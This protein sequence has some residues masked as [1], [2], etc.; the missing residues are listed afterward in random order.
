MWPKEFLPCLI[1]P[2]RS[3]RPTVN[4]L[5]LIRP[6]S[7]LSHRFH[8]ESIDYRQGS[9]GTRSTSSDDGL[10]WPLPCPG[11]KLVGSGLWLTG[12]LKLLKVC[13][14]LLTPGR[15]ERK[16]TLRYKGLSITV[17]RKGIH[18]RVEDR[19]SDLLNS[20]FLLS[21][22]PKPNSFFF[23]RNNTLEVAD[24]WLHVMGGWNHPDPHTQI[25]THPSPVGL[26]LDRVNHLYP[27]CSRLSF[28]ER[29]DNNGKDTFDLSD[30]WKS[31]CVTLPGFTICVV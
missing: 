20:I 5:I 13:P 28:E 11:T 2:T 9:R 26:L 7:R 1:Q 31:N 4:S 23:C 24:T 29:N 27:T 12:W 17:W 19:E 8:G 30:W 18:T 21:K 15:E 14:I 6:V 25:S 10:L 16:I 22:Q 3:R